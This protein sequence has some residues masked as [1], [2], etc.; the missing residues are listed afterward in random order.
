MFDSLTIR[1]ARDDDA[2]A[3]LELAVVDSASQLGGEVLVAEVEGRPW[4]AL[5][6][7][8]GRVIADPF[9]RTAEVVEL[10]RV[11]EQ[12]LFGP[13]QDGDRKRRAGMYAGRARWST[14]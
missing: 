1:L 13:R 11:R 5:E 12:A 9:K 7:G 10:L 3:L 2:V 8:S 6:L 4:A 14:R